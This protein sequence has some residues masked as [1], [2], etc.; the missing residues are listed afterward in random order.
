MIS[1]KLLEYHSNK[2]EEEEQEAVEE[3]TLEN[4]DAEE[5]VEEEV[6]VVTQ[7]NKKQAKKNEV[8]KI[9]QEQEELEEEEDEDE[10]RPA[11]KNNNTSNDVV[12]V[13]SVNTTNTV[14]ISNYSKPIQKN[15]FQRIDNSRIDTLKEELKDNSFHVR[16]FINFRKCNINLFLLLLLSINTCYSL[17]PIPSFFLLVNVYLL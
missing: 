15:F 12:K 16:I 11:F 5:E 14:P 4:N 1:S 2:V 6:K 3:E 8:K 13:N 10:P 17:R 7:S 9:E